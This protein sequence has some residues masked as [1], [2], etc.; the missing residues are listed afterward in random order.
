MSFFYLCGGVFAWICY[1]HHKLFAAFRRKINKRPLCGDAWNWLNHYFWG[2]W[3]RS[4]SRFRSFCLFLQ[5][6]EPFLKALA[7]QRHRYFEVEV[8]TIF[9]CEMHRQAVCTWKLDQV[10]F[11][12]DNSTQA[13]LTRHRM[14]MNFRP[15]EKFDRTLRSHGTVRYFRD[16]YTELSSHVELYNTNNNYF[17]HLIH[18]T[19]CAKK[20][21]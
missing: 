10:P 4:S 15:V 16:V 13:T 21:A 17:W 6:Q 3:R 8:T 11:K 12:H 14:I 5:R 1:P 7:I 19:S 9:K 20:V 2:F 18:R